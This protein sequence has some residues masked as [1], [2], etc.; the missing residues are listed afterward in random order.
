MK[1][2]EVAIDDRETTVVESK[3]DIAAAELE[4]RSIDEEYQTLKRLRNTATDRRKCVV[5][6]STSCSRRVFI[7]LILL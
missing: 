3:I 2:T 6:P 4:I 1:T 7:L 5:C